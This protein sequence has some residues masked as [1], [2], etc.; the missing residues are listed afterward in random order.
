MLRP[1][2]GALAA[3]DSV[4]LADDGQAGTADCGRAGS[5]QRVHREASGTKERGRVESR[6]SMK[7]L[8]PWMLPA[9]I[10]RG[11]WSW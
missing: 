7:S 1:V 4:L 5:A 9:P 10:L 6:N 3:L 11:S 2:P 8:Q